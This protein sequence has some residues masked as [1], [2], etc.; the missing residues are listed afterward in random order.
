VT[1][2]PQDAPRS[3]DGQWWWDGTQWQPTTAVATPGSPPPVAETGELPRMRRS[4]QGW[5]LTLKA[6]DAAAVERTL[7]PNGMPPGVTLTAHSVNEQDQIGS[8]LIVGLT[9]ETVQ[10]MEPS[11]ANWMAQAVMFPSEPEGSGQHPQ[12]TAPAQRE[13]TQE[14]A[15]FEW[16]TF[17]SEGTKTVLEIASWFAEEGSKFLTFFEGFAGP[18]GDV[19]ML[20]DMFSAVIEAFQEEMKDEK[21]HGYVFGLIWQVMGLPNVAPT[22]RDANSPQWSMHSFEEHVEAFNDGVQEG[23]SKASS[24]LVLHN[25]IAARIAYHMALEHSTENSAAQDTLTELANAAGWS[26]PFQLFL[27]APQV[28]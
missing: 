10:T 28:N 9:M 16:R 18:V 14:Q 27:N 24:D 25:S 8:F 19:M 7:W 22:M 2:I 1:V 4:E 11:W 23:R 6:T 21:R 17:I 13:I 26:D 15:E 5:V 20:Y 12:G 3:D